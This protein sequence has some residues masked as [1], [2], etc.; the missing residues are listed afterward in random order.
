MYIKM[1]G[2]LTT[3]YPPNEN[4]DDHDYMLPGVLIEVAI[5]IIN[6]DVQYARIKLIVFCLVFSI[7]GQSGFLNW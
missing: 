7:T 1:V 4:N 5:I 3:S 2:V 6:M